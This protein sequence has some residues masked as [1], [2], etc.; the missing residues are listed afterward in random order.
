M[1]PRKSN[2]WEVMNCGREA[3]GAC[4]SELGVCQVAVW[5]VRDGQ[6]GG[7]NAGR[8]CWTVPGTLCNGVT[9]SSFAE[10]QLSCRDCV[11][12]KQVIKEEGDGFVAL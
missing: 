8:M 3:D 6:N 9:Q 7:I 2:C 11:F 4:A 10:K 1:T 12:L 5:R